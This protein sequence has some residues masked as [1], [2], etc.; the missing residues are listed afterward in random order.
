[1]IMVGRAGCNMILCVSI[2]CPAR[3]KGNQWLG[4]EVGSWE[5]LEVLWGAYGEVKWSLKFVNFVWFRRQW[6]PSSTC[7]SCYLP[8]RR[9]VRSATRR[10]KP[11]LFEAVYRTI[12]SWTWRTAPDRPQGIIHFLIRTRNLT[13]HMRA[14]CSWQHLLVRPSNVISS[15]ETAE[16]RD[17]ATADSDK[18]WTL[19]A[20]MVFVFSRY[21][22]LLFVDMRTIY[23]TLP[24]I[25]YS[26]S[27]VLI[28]F[29]RIVFR[30]VFA[31]DIWFKHVDR[32]YSSAVA[33]TTKWIVTTTN[34]SYPKL[35]AVRRHMATWPATTWPG[36]QR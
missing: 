18:R 33:S 23:S 19:S 32:A 11:R 24:L 2:L 1:M 17:W 14:C 29:T 13:H 6:S 27:L 5:W 15:M 8:A 9:G 16:Y 21:L 31:L 30:W 7:S 28:G 20:W 35:L 25:L 36:T 12:S 22:T 26:N 10:S 4:S 34:P 3:Q